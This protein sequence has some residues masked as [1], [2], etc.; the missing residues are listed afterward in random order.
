M[1]S[2]LHCGSSLPQKLFLE[3]LSCSDNV[4]ASLL[5]R[6]LKKTPQL[7]NDFGK[8][9]RELVSLKFL[10]SLFLQGARANPVSYASRKKVRLDPSDL[11]EDVLRRILSETSVSQ[12]L[13]SAGLEISKWDLEPFIE[14]KKSSLPRL[15]ALKQLKD[16]LL[17]G[18]PSSLSSLKECSGLPVGSHTEHNAPAEGGKCN[19]NTPRAECHTDDGNLLPR[20]LPDENLVPV[21]R[22]KRASESPAEQLD[23]TCINPVKKNRHDI[24]FNEQNVGEQ[25]ISSAVHIQITDASTVTLLHLKGK[26]FG[27]E[28][29][30]VKPYNHDTIECTSSGFVDSNGVLPCEKKVPHCDNGQNNKPEEQQRQEQNIQEEGGKN[31]AGDPKTTNDDVDRFEL[32]MN[33]VHE[34]K[35]KSHVCNDN[36]GNDGGKTEIARKENALHSLQNTCSQDPLE[37]TNSGARRC[38]LEKETRVEVMRQNGSPGNGN[39]HCNSSK[40]LV[41]N[42]HVLPDCGTEVLNEEGQTRE[43]GGNGFHGL[44]STNEDIDKYDQ[45]VPRTLPTVGEAE[46]DVDIFSDTDGYH[47]ERTTIDTQKK[48]FLS[49]QYICS[50]NT[51]ATTSGREQ[52]ICMKCRRGGDLLSCTSDSC[53]IVIHE[54][55]LGSDVSFDTGEAFCCPFCAYSRA[56]SKYLEV[57]KLAILARKDFATFICLGPENEPNKQS[58]GSFGMDGNCLKQNDGLPKSNDLNQINVVKKVSNHQERKKLEYEQAGPSKLR[59]VFSPPLRRKAADST[60]RVH[61]LKTDKQDG[62]GITQES[63]RLRDCRRK[64]IG[65]EAVHNSQRETVVSETSGSKKHADVRSKKGVPRLP[66]TDLPCEHKCSQ[67]SQS[68]DAEELSEA[69]NEGSGGSKICLRVRKQE[70]RNLNPAIPHFRRKNIPWTSEEEEKLK[71]GMRVC[72]GPYD[73]KIPWTKILGHGEGIFHPS[74]T[75][76]NLKD[77]W[78]NICKASSKSKL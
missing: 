68:N 1:D 57:K 16:A 4:E 20:D 13:K 22:K 49:S 43:N 61:S 3:A 74:R 17:T 73:A 71:E 58:C 9:T 76:I 45:N 78:R 52:H 39:N 29:G 12:H 19:V 36:D 24:I 15:Y 41:G 21:N 37:T 38:S 77:K 27:L 30:L 53:P 62:K 64:Q 46:D 33:N 25:V 8:N 40:E 56:I 75:T 31:E 63:Q 48:T 65:V 18:S 23:T 55:C 67:S 14:H 44:T 5:L 35:E 32:H 50:Q 28:R 69:E 51:L 2:Q 59:S 70:R 66:E 11:C 7:L 10:E 6:L 72:C 60:D 47:D 42:F 54:N 26:R 34:V